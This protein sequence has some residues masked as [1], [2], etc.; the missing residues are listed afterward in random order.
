[1]A[2]VRR[3][4][5]RRVESVA[6]KGDGDRVTVIARVGAQKVVGGDRTRAV[7]RAVGTRFEVR[8]VSGA[9]SRTGGSGVPPSRHPITAIIHHTHANLSSVGRLKNVCGFELVITITV[10]QTRTNLVYVQIYTCSLCA[11]I[12]M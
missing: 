1:M 3:E 7:A 5:N 11:N 8:D 4:Y 9:R 6:V 12:Y 10:N 2:V